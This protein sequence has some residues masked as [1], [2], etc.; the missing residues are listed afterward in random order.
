MNK[1]YKIILHHRDEGL[2]HIANQLIKAKTSIDEVE[3]ILMALAVNSC[4]PPFDVKE[5]KRK[6]RSAI[7]RHLNAAIRDPLENIFVDKENCLTLKKVQN[8]TEIY[9]E[10][11]SN[12]ILKPEGQ[13]IDIRS[14]KIIAFKITKLTKK[15]KP[16]TAIIATH[17]TNKYVNEFGLSEKQARTMSHIVSELFNRGYDLNDNEIPEIKGYLQIGWLNE[18]SYLHP[19]IIDE[20]DYTWIPKMISNKDIFLKAKSDLE[21]LKQILHICSGSYAIVPILFSLFTLHDKENG[22]CLEITGKTSCGKS[23]ILNNASY[24]MGIKPSTWN[25]TANAI[26]ETLGFYQNYP[27]FIDEIHEAKDETVAQIIYQ[28]LQQEGRKRLNRD[29]SFRET[30]TFNVSLITTGEYGITNIV[31]RIKN[32]RPEGLIKRTISISAQTQEELLGEKGDK[33]KDLMRILREKA[34]GT[35]LQ[36]WVKENKKNDFIF[37]RKGSAHYIRALDAMH[38]INMRLYE[39]GL[40][41]EDDRL[42][43]AG[44]LEIVKTSQKVNEMNVYTE[45][46]YKEII[47][48]EL[49][50][51]LPSMD[52][53]LEQSER[54]VGEII[55]WYKKDE[56]GITYLVK[57]RP[58]YK[59]IASLQLDKTTIINQPWVNLVKKKIPAAK[60]MPYSLFEISHNIED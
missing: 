36:I 30:K 3:M 6:V 16:Y 42:N 28:L 48:Q 50:A 13:I 21:A 18:T 56:N 31:E 22:L 40:I 46:D 55:G 26:T 51:K 45:K 33:I 24:L 14:K 37:T 12:C 32:V 43:N 23:I 25:A 58:F 38:D 5:A 57:R 11:I 20:K 54:K 19:A 47:L 27:I 60:N 15:A 1:K 41:T 4:D 29:G 49:H 44:I 2:F 53:Y 39:M 59:M 9:N 8:R 7:N 34:Q 52:D 35:L 17:T 10:I